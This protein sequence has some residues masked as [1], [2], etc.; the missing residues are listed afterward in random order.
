MWLAISLV[1]ILA[2]LA[3]FLVFGARPVRHKSVAAT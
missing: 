2:L 3:V 1:A